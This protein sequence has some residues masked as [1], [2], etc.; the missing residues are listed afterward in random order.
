MCENW[1][2]L[3]AREND[4]AKSIN[5]QWASYFT[6]KSIKKKGSTYSHIS[7][8]EKQFPSTSDYSPVFLRPKRSSK[9]R[10]KDFWLSP[11]PCQY[12]NI[13]YVSL[14]LLLKSQ[15]ESFTHL[16]LKGGKKLFSYPLKN[17]YQTQQMKI[18]D[19]E[20][21]SKESSTILKLN[22]EIN[23]IFITSYSW[24]TP[25]QHLYIH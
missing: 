20:N 21:T 14:Y 10:N 1:S 11:T 7:L 25:D 9:T 3:P 17:N 5:I 13:R 6:P 22:K 12:S 24:H 23:H 8:N 18:A 15:A 16:Y 2:W 4:T 19:L